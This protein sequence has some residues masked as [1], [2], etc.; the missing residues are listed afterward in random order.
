MRKLNS[1]E[2]VPIE[3]TSKL[4]PEESSNN[5]IGFDG[6]ERSGVLT[7]TRFNGNGAKKTVS[8]P[9]SQVLSVQ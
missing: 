6:K 3:L 8:Q 9:E 1:T 5:L 4:S 2:V 7:M